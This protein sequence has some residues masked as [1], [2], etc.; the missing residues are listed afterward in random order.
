MEDYSTHGVR[1]QIR[2]V[3]IDAH[4]RSVSVD[5]VMTFVDTDWRAEVELHVRALID[6]GEVKL[7]GEYLRATQKLLR[8]V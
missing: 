7:T 3:L 1:Q 8:G 6:T 2:K 5:G 4:P